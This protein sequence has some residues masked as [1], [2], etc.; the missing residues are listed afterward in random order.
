MDDAILIAAVLL[1]STSQILQKL[2]ATRHLAAA[3][4]PGEW[5]RSLLSVELCAAVAA[6]GLGTLLW[7]VALYR[8]DVGRAFPFLSLGS[9]LVVAFS[10]L[11]LHESVPVHRWIGVGLICAGIIL[12]GST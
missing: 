6:I 11:Y 3:R 7:L 8:M 5:L 10:R 2:A 12:V 4:T 9:V 1:I